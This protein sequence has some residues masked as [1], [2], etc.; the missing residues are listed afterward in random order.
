[1]ESDAKRK[2]RKRWRQEP[3]L[4]SFIRDVE[5]PRRQGGLKPYLLTYLLWFETSA[6]TR[7]E[8]PFLASAPEGRLQRIQTGA[9]IRQ[10]RFIRAFSSRSPPLAHAPF[11]PTEPGLLPTLNLIGRTVTHYAIGQ[12]LHGKTLHLYRWRQSPTMPRTRRKT[13]IPRALLRCDSQSRAPVFKR[14]TF[15]SLLSYSNDD[16]APLPQMKLYD[17]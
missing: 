9:R 12:C 15:L 3:K 10:N 6:G 13:P 14:N 4:G 5:S 7:T 17:T 1:M 16:S 8:G 11:A 2:R